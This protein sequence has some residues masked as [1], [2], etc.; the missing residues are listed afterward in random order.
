MFSQNKRFIQ[1][2][3]QQQPQH[4]PQQHLQQLPEQPHLQPQQLHLQQDNF[5][6][7]NNYGA[8]SNQRL[9]NQNLLQP[10]NGLQNVQFTGKQQNKNNLYQKVSLF[11]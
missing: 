9:M 4:Q 2:Q 5:G 6:L 10:N 1:Q 3:Q 7:L 8:S 11:F